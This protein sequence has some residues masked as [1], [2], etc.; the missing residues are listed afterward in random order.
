MDLIQSSVLTDTLVEEKQDD[1]EGSIPERHDYL[2]TLLSLTQHAVRQANGIPMGKAYS[3]KTSNPQN[4]RGA[5][6]TSVAVMSELFQILSF[7]CPEELAKGPITVASADGL[8]RNYEKLV[9]CMELLLGKVDKGLNICNTKHPTSSM[10][11]AL[12]IEKD[13]RTEKSAISIKPTEYANRQSATSQPVLVT[14]PTSY[15]K[16]SKVDAGRFVPTLTTKPHA[17][18]P[19]DDVF[20]EAQRQVA[21]IQNKKTST[22]IVSL[23][24]L[25]HPYEEEIRLLNWKDKSTPEGRLDMFRSREPKIYCPMESTPLVWVRT[26]SELD[27]MVRE[28]RDSRCG[29]IAMDVEHHSHHSY[30]G[31]TCLIQ[32]ST[33]NKDF[34]IDPV[35]I[36]EALVKLNEVTANPGIVKVLHGADSDVIWLQRDFS[37]YIVNLF[38]TG[39][40]ARLMELPGGASLANLMMFYCKVLLQFDHFNFIMHFIR[41]IP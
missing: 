25:P 17:V 10:S 8:L 33:R 15:W 29:E 27:E 18:S 31:I 20:R 34:V 16:Y 32:L 28:I 7:I 35:D 13:S 9:D 39:R 21:T 26:E 30:H 14:A 1:E 6:E 24:S 37:I 5:G 38:D 41:I 2:T 36:Q 22:T 12:S 4:S 3:I 11:S 40:A 23:P 19:L